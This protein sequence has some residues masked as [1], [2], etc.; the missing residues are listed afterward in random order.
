MHLF[1]KTPEGSKLRDE[2]WESRDPLHRGMDQRAFLNLQKEVKQHPET[3]RPVKETREY[4][5]WADANRK[6]E[7]IS[8]VLF[9]PPKDISGKTR[10]DDWNLKLNTKQQNIINKYKNL[11]GLQQQVQ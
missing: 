9:G 2:C 11:L 7:T 3:G 8:T 4:H 5:K 6:D 1:N 10:E